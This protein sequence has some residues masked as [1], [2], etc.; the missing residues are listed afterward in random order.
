MFDLHVPPRNLDSSEGV[1][2][3]TDR[4]N[5][6]RKV[7]SF[8]LHRQHEQDAELMYN[9]LKAKSVY[10]KASWNEETILASLV[11]NDFVGVAIAPAMAQPILPPASSPCPLPVVIFDAPTTHVD[12]GLQTDVVLTTNCQLD[13]AY[14]YVD[15]FPGIPILISGCS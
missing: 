12:C 1:V 15:N 9:Q 4:N 5:H 13:S 10:T 14:H 6:H 2:R 3:F 11:D 8:E 7:G